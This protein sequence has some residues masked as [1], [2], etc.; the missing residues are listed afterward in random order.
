MMPEVD[1]DKAYLVLL[2]KKVAWQ[3]RALEAEEE[4]RILKRLC[5]RLLEETAERKAIRGE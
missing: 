1:K 4:V 5:S 2:D 3:R